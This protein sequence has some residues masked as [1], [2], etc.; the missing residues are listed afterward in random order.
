MGSRWVYRAIVPVILVAGIAATLIMKR[1]EHSNVESE[2]ATRAPSSVSQS[3]LPI[4]EIQFQPLGPDSNNLRSRSG[5][6]TRSLAHAFHRHTRHITNSRQQHRQSEE[7]IESHDGQKFFLRPDLKAIPS[8][9]Y[10]T[11]LGKQVGQI[12]GFSIV[13]VAGLHDSQLL[14]GTDSSFP[15]AQHISNRRY[16]IIT[17]TFVV[18]FKSLVDSEIFARSH[19]LSVE[20]AAPHIKTAFFKSEPGTDLTSLQKKL[21]ADISVVR[22]ELEIIT[23]QDVPK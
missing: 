5:T 10:S 20:G 3:N 22:A 19:G 17:G 18:V 11:Q 2:T 8:S 21:R 6:E 1:K 14:T 9:Q 7:T 16:G 4:T 15:V 23:H 12:P 13:R